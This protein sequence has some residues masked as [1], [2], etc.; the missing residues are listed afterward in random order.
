MVYNDYR[1]L[2]VYYRAVNAFQDY[3]VLPAK[4][5]TVAVGEIRSDCFNAGTFDLTLFLNINSTF[6]RY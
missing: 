1:G 6:K 3:M 4:Y 5:A 2:Y